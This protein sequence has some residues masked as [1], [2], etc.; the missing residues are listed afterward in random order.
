M[1]HTTTFT[2]SQCGKTKTHESEISTGYGTDKD[3]NKVCFDCCG[4]NDAKELDGLQKGQK[5]IQ[6]WNGEAITNWPG[7]L[8]IKPYYKTKGR[9]NIAGTREDIYF[10]FN[11]NNFHA[12]Q[13]GNNSQIAHIRKIK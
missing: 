3:G 4:L 12:T 2:C 6:Y 10:R 5:A 8:V 9:H 7:T 1:L 11:G 13:Y